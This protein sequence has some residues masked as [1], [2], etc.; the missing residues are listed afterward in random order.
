MCHRPLHRAQA[1]H[2]ILLR[3]ELLAHDIGV[4]RRAAG[5]ARPPSPQGHP[6]IC[7]AIPAP[8]R[9]RHPRRS[10]ASPCSANS[11]APPR[12]A[13][14][15][16]RKASAPASPTPRPAPANRSSPTSPSAEDLRS[17]LHSLNLPST[18]GGQF[19]ISAAGQFAVSHDSKTST[20][21]HSITTGWCLTTSNSTQTR[22]TASVDGGQSWMTSWPTARRALAGPTSERFSPVGV[23]SG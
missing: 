16:S 12:S 19:L 10:S 9:A 20:G 5:T 23:T 11:P 13:S 4:A 21:F 18:G 3:G 15:P 7:D 1:H 8:S 14:S 2:D 6:A 22:R 17:S